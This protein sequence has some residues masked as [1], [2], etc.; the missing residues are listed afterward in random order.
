[1]AIR[2]KQIRAMIEEILTR[3]SDLESE[4]EN[5][6]NML[7]EKCDEY[8]DLEKEHVDLED[9][10]SEQELKIE[11]LEEALMEAYLTGEKDEQSC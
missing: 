2:D 3:V 7:E 6:E 8:N 11:E 10:C 9:K 1:M 5:L 4:I